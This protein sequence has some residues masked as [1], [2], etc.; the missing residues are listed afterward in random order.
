MLTEPAQDKETRFI[1]N[2]TRSKMDEYKAKSCEMAA[3]RREPLTI[4]Y[5]P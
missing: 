3:T 1:K 4:N 5:E 2:W